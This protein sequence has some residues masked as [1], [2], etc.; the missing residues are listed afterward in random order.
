[1]S[2]EYSEDH[3]VENATQDVLEELGRSVVTAW[4]NETFGMDGLLGRDNKTEVI[5]RK[6]LLPALRRLNPGLPSVAYEQAAEQI[7]QRRSDQSP[8]QTNRDKYTLF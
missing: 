3:L 4:K 2:H 5:L 1:M 8:A 7:E 6:Y